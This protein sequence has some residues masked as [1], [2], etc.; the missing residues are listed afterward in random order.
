MMPL[1]VLHDR[2]FPC[3]SC[4]VFVHQI[5]QVSTDLAA[6]TRSRRAK[7]PRLYDYDQPMAALEHAGSLRTPGD[8][9]TSLLQPVYSVLDRSENGL[10][11]GRDATPPDSPDTDS[12]LH[13]LLA[14]STVVS[15]VPG[16]PC[17]R[18]PP[19]TFRSLRLQV[20]PALAQFLH[21]PLLHL[22]LRCD[23]TMYARPR[24]PCT[25]LLG[26]PLC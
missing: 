2:H 4:A 11:A 6:T 21:V 12:P 13:C 22:E 19:L 25:C 15:W 8:C 26:T 3:A 7:L 14:R 16:Y 23:C 9:C 18:P 5:A 17:G 20:S 24:R 10:S 1:Y